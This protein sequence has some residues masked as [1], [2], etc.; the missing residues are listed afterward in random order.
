MMP[1]ANPDSKDGLIWQDFPPGL[2]LLRT[3]P[4]KPQFSYNGSELLKCERG[5]IEPRSAFLYPSH[6][7]TKQWSLDTGD[8][9]LD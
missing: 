8:G 9:E 2:M 6:L 7:Y 1:V 5:H 3:D 4:L